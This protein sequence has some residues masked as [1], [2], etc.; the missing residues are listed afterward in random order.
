M[1]KYKDKFV[2][3]SLYVTHLPDNPL[4][5]A[6]AKSGTKYDNRKLYFFNCDTKFCIKWEDVSVA[7]R[8]FLTTKEGDIK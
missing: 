2:S 8:V 4:K 6:I 5:M 3:N 7:K 1:S